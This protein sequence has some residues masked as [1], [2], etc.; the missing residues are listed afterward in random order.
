MRNWIAATVALAGAIFWS[1]AYAQAPLTPPP[2][3]T[4]D[5]AGVTAWLKAHIKMEG[6][7]LIGADGVA[8]ALGSPDG[9]IKSSDGPMTAK[10][11]HEYYR[12]VRLGDMD[13]RS[14]LQTWNVD[15]EGGRLQVVSI[16]IYEA[17]N[18]EGRSQAKSNPDAA[19]SA[20]E[21]ASLRGRTVKRICEAPTTGKRLK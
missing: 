17:S 15:C 9:V 3:A 18:L 2:P 10:I 13:S 20:V 8:V 1:G 21:P 6:W 14:N 12:P 4:I 7:T 5:D 19:W 16:A 11:R